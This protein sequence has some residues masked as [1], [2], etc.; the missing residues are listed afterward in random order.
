MGTDLTQSKKVYVTFHN[1]GVK[2][3]SLDFYDD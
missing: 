1:G 2:E 3:L